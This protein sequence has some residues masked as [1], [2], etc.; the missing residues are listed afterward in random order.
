MR[1]V[2]VIGAGKTGRGFVARLLNESGVHVNFIDKNET[3][4][5]ALRTDDT[6]GW[7]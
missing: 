3:L 1:N 5:N 7:S 4:V 6:S 2:T